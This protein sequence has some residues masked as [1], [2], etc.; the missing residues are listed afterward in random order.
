MTG[1]IMTL[2]RIEGD[3][4]R[5]LTRFCNAYIATVVSDE[6]IAMH[7][8]VI[9]EVHRFP[10]IGQTFFGD[11]VET[12]WLIVA[13]FL[14]QLFPD[15]DRIDRA[16]TDAAE[17]LTSLCHGRSFLRRVYGVGDQPTPDDIEDDTHVAVTTFLRAFAITEHH[18]C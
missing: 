15:N 13:D 9:G 5:S 4:R 2:A 1:Q 12:V 7:R 17:L 16:P 6:V 3:A 11:A 8:L 10:Q 18:P 14:R